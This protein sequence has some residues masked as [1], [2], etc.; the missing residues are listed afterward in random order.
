MTVPNIQIRDVPPDVHQRVKAQAAL[1]GQ[2]LNEFLLARV[3]ELVGT[4]TLGELV[5]EL[6]QGEPY[7][8]PS[9]A[10]VVRELRGRL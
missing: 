4:P 8:G 9:S 7:A 2:S 1:A 10:A 6:R 5:A 3:T